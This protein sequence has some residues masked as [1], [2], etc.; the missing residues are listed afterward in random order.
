MAAASSAPLVFLD[1]DGV[2][3]CNTCRQL[4]DDKLRL[5]QRVCLATGAKVVLSSDWRRQTPLKQKV[6]RALARLKIAYV[7]CTRV[8]T[9]SEQV[10]SWRIETNHRPREI[11]TWL[12]SRSCAWIAIDDRDLLSEPGGSELQ[13]HFV[14]TNPVTGLTP[15]LVTKAIDSLNQQLQLPPARELLRVSAPLQRAR[16]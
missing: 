9:V 16:T 1:I 15:D 13:G 2:I 7:G 14:R 11:L 5:L 12:G 8:I 4:E 6:Q 3:C 10:G